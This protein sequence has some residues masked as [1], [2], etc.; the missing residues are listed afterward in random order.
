MAYVAVDKD[1]GE[2]VYDEEPTRGDEIFYQGY[3]DCVELPRGTIQ[4]MIGRPLT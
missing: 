2:Y 3:G 1:G 4:K